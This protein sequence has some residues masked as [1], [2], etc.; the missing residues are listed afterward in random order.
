MAIFTEGIKVLQIIVNLIGGGIAIL[1][2]IQL[3][4]AQSDQN[5]AQKQLGISQF[6]TGGGICIVANTLIP[7][8]GNMMG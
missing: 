2:I 3:L 7:M 5:A 8:L 4:Q 6:I 1:G